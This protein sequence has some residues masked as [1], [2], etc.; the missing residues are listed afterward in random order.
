VF[1]AN[2]FAPSLHFAV[3]YV[4]GSDVSIGNS[5]IFSPGTRQLFN[6][7]QAVDV[8]TTVDLLLAVDSIVV[9]FSVVLTNADPITGD[10]PLQMQ[11][12]GY[13]YEFQFGDTAAV[14]NGIVDPDGHALSYAASVGVGDEPLPDWLNFSST[15]LTF[16]G[17]PVTTTATSAPLLINIDAEDKYGG[18]VRVSF[19][20]D[21]T[22]ANPV[23]GETG[24]AH[25]SMGASVKN[26]KSLVRHTSR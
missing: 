22:N 26:D 24:L 2:E 18:S 1:P 7:Q 12:V 15:D 14:T 17:L 16:S 5:W 4:N 23:L 13:H 21:L 20:L 11:I 9:P 19:E 3:S 10:F 6:V 25:E 8:N